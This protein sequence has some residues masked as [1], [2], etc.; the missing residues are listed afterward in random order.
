[1]NRAVIEE[2]VHAAIRPQLD[3]ADEL[4]D[5]YTEGLPREVWEPILHRVAADHYGHPP[6]PPIVGSFAELIERLSGFV[7]DLFDRFETP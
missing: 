7:E 2:R 5:Y 1:M 3:R 6:Y 4:L